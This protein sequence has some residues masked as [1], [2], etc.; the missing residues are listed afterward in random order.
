MLKKNQLDGLRGFEIHY[1]ESVQSTNTT[2]FHLLS[3]SAQCPLV[4]FAGEQTAGRGQR[5]KT[6]CSGRDSLTFSCATRFDQP[7]KRLSVLPTLLG[8]TVCDAIEETT[9]KLKPQLK[10]PNDVIINDSKVSGILVETSTRATAIDCVVGIGINVADDQGEVFKKVQSLRQCRQLKPG[11]LQQWIDTKIPATDLFLHV[12]RGV[13]K[14]FADLQSDVLPAFDIAAEK[15]WRFQSEVNVLKSDGRIVRGV[16]M[17]VGPDG[18]LL[19]KI[20]RQIERIYS[21]SM[22]L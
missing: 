17:G 15:L 12:C 10:W 5:G 19:L 13:R 18:A 8:I 1:F 14:T 21:G 22:M 11:N 2:A 4:V 20:N 3:Q 6:W 7:L 9:G 16:H